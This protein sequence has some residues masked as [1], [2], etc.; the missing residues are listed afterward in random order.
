MKKNGVVR[1]VQ[2]HEVRE[3]AAVLAG[4]AQWAQP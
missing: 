3:D 2:M 4:K 1:A